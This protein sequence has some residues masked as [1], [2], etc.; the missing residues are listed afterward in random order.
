[1]PVR[2]ANRASTFFAA[3]ALMLTSCAAPQE[4]AVP[5]A[6]FDDGIVKVKSAYPI[7]ETVARLKQDVADKGIQFFMDVDQAGLAADAGIA[8]RPSRLLV[9]GNPPLGTQFITANP[10]AGLDW[11]VRLLVAEDDNGDVWAVYSDF[12]WIKRRHQIAGRDPQFKMASEVIAS[13]TASVAAP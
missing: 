1:M 6:G 5:Q 13:I 10:N 7:D 9:F 2:L 12:E 8:L 3:L 4:A 11:P